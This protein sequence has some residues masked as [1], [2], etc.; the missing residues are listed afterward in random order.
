MVGSFLV[1]SAHMMQ[2]TASMNRLIKTRVCARFRKQGD[3]AC[4]VM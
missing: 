1:N 4:E 2:K 3:D